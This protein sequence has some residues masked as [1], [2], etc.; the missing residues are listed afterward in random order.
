MLVGCTSLVKKINGEKR[1]KIENQESLQQFISENSLDIDLT[2]T[3]FLK[4]KES[5]EKIIAS[6]MGYVDRNGLL[7]AYGL[8]LFDEQGE[9]LRHDLLD[10]CLKDEIIS[11]NFYYNVVERNKTEPKFNLS[12]LQNSFID[13]NGNDF[14]PFE[15]NGKATAIVVWAKYKGKKWAGET[16]YFIRTLQQSKADYDIY[17]LNLDPNTFYS[18][19]K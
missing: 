15:K 16:N 9:M 8:Y 12:E 11:E 18:Q 6:K 19:F 4:N 5:K 14:F 7:I 3:F 2:K 17:Y 10:E 1:P 13:Y